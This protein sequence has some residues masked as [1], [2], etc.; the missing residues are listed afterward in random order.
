M[1]GDLSQSDSHRYFLELIRNLP[2]ESQDL[3][4]SD[5]RSFDEIFHL[6]GGR[7][8]LI[9]NYVNQVVRTMA[10]TRILPNGECG[11]AI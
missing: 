8:M 10:S 9:E 7:M 6:T 3:F 2:L 11:I 5:E 4:Q 1:V